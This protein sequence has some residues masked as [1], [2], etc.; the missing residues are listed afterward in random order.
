ML[1]QTTLHAVGVEHAEG[2]HQTVF[3]MLSVSHSEIVVWIFIR[4]V[5]RIQVILTT[6]IPFQVAQ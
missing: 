1:L 4:F 5:T 2:T 3:V 6:Q